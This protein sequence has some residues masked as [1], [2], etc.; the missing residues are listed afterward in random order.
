MELETKNLSGMISQVLKRIST[1]YFNSDG[2]ADA[3]IML[4]PFPIFSRTSIMNPCINLIFKIY[5]WEEKQ[6]PLIYVSTLY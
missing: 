1:Y 2:G 4:I 3:C 5:I 6:F